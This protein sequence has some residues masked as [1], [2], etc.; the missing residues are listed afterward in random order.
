MLKRKKKIGKRI[1]LKEIDQGMEQKRRVLSWDPS[2]GEIPRDRD[3][4]QKHGPSQVSE[5]TGCTDSIRKD[6]DLLETRST[7]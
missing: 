6:G 3:R 7:V 2:V 5:S 1:K 4:P